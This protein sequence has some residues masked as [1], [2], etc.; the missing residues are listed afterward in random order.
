M[1]NSIKALVAAVAL[2]GAAGQAHADIQPGTTTIGAEGSELVFYAFDDVAKSSFV[3]DLGVTFA[4]FVAG[5]T[6]SYSNAGSNNVSSTGN[7]A[8]YLTSVGGD[9]G[10]TKWGVLGSV[11]TGA[12]GA[13]TQQIITTARNNTTANTQS[14][15]MRGI[16]GAFNT[17]YLNAL[18]GAG[19]NYAV[20]DSYFQTGA[21]NNANWAAGLQH[22][23]A[24]KVSFLSDNA[25]GVGADFFKLSTAS[26]G[27]AAATTTTL[28]SGSTEWM[29][30]GNSVYITAATAPVPEPGTWA[31]LIAGLMMVSG[32]A[33]RRLS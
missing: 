4:S 8:S 27:T 21:S 3:L 11:K 19:N 15:L 12:T 14:S 31:M 7:W 1:R 2:V 25:V 5:P 17:T 10:N 26:L 32:I 30:D 13:N 23:L 20:N 24:G 29:F 22:N 6:Y 9:L 18:Q 28:F 33:R 16:D